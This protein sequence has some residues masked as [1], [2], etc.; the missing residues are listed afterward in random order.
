[1]PKGYW[2]ARV[3]V[4][5][6]EGYQQYVAANAA[7]FRKFGARFIVRGG[8]LRRRRGSPAHA[9]WSLSFRT[10]RPPLP[11]TTH[12]NIWRPRRCGWGGRRRIC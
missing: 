10:M 2:I 11:A 12:P 6:P 4:S 1:M 9:T 7:A 5:D 8:D 3:D